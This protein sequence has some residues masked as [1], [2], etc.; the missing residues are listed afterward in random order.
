[1]KTTIDPATTRPEASRAAKPGQAAARL[2]QRIRGEYLEMPGMIL[3]PPQA[4]RLWALDERKA[5]RLLEELVHEGFLICTA[6][7]AYRLGE[8]PR[9][10]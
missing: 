5:E 7:G 8:C 3:T 10:P 2:V 1:M 6:E 4:A 9:C